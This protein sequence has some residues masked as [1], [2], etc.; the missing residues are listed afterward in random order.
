MATPD[1]TIRIGQVGLEQDIQRAIQRVNSKGGLNVKLNSRSFTQPLG[2]ITAS[3]DEFT[4]SIEA[5]NARVIA[6]GASVGIINAITGA[7]KNLITETVALEKRLTE[8]NVV[9]GANSSQLESFGKQLFGVARNTAQSFNTVSEAALEFSRQ[10][11]SMEETLKRTQ[12]ALILTRLTGL[13]AAD[14]VKGLTATINSFATAGLN[15]A[16][17]ISKLA[18]VDV[19]FAVSSEDLINALSRAGAVAQDAGLDF[20]QLVAAVTSA[21]QI[22]ARGGAVIGNSFKTIFTRIQRSDTLDRLQEL[23]I[24]VRNVHGETLPA[25]MILQQLAH[26]YD[27]LADATKS[28]VAEQVGGV[29]QINVLKAALKDLS[30]ENSIYSRA[31]TTSAGATD[32]AIRKNDQLNQTLAALGS[33]AL[34]SIKELSAAVGEIT[35]GPGIEKVLNMVND[36]AQG[37]TKLLDGEGIG[38]NLANGILKGIGTIIS[39]P[40]LIII[41]GLIG[42]LFVDVTTFAAKSFKNIIGLN[43]GAQQQKALQDSIFNTLQSNERINRVLAQL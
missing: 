28:A 6:F 23:G 5:S 12:D 9:L 22:T 3:A 24:A 13:K 2:K 36:L 17:I 32:E 21:Q 40:G 35:V 8:V 39:G 38:S 42:K 20:D 10:G 7:F 18:A 29:F 30:S 25:M 11:L 34:V 14:S 4:K 41:G 31:V 16:E 15:T 1:A 27:G 37:A 33:Q 26:T 43:K 19:E